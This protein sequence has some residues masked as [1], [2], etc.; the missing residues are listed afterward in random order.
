MDKYYSKTHEWVK[1]DGEEAIVGISEYAAADLGDITF[2]ELPKDGTDLI[3]GDSV[4]TIESVTASS[5]V[6]SPVSGT[7][8]AVNHALDD[9]AGLIN[10][11]AEGKGWLYKL[12][13]IDEAELEDLMSEEDYAAYLETL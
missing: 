12:E 13:N 2:V 1:T 10:K 11:S 8:T 7:V 4:G 5:E 9:D 6:F 3:C